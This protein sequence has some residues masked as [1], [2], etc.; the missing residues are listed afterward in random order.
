MNHVD[1]IKALLA[2]ACKKADAA[3]LAQWEADGKMDCGTCGGAMLQLDSRTVLAKLAIEA[4]LASK[5]GS[6]VYVSL[7][8]PDGVRS[9]NMAIPV[10]QMEAFK[11]ELIA[12]GAGTVIRRYWSYV[13]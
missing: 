2:D 10:K 5:S 11:A 4:G 3:A 8:L 7:K 9:Q 12:Q 1:K 6:A 13:D